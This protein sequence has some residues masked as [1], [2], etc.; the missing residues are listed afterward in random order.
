MTRVVLHIDRLVLRGFPAAD[1]NR[2]AAGLRSELARH[3]ADPTHSTHLRSMPHVPRLDG[4]RVTLPRGGEATRT[5][6]LV[7][8]AVARRLSR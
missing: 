3:F 2:I 1:R 8:S 6:T 5:G 7:G 4:G